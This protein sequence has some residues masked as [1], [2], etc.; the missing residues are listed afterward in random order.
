M[1]NNEW[2]LAQS[3]P[4]QIADMDHLIQ[5][6][7]THRAEYDAAKKLSAD[8]YHRLEEVEKEVINALKANNRTKFEAEGVALVYIT[9]KEV[10]TTPKTPEQKDEFFGYIRSKYGPEVLTGMLSVNHQTLNSFANK[11]TEADP[12]LNIPGLDAPTSV[13]TLTFRR[14]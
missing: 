1:E 12:T 8:A 11:E 13:E 5:K 6:L 7:Q 4:T 14:K 2:G 9:T 3:A 10:Y